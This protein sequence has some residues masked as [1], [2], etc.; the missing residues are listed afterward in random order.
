MGGIT[1]PTELQTIVTEMTG[2]FDSVKSAGVTLVIAA[3]SLGL[4]FVGAQWLWGK[5]KTW[6][7]KA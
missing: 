6:L 1:M 4:I 2:I 5:T 7:K 3:I